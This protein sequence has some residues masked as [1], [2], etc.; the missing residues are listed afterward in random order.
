M[1]ASVSSDG[2]TKIWKISD[3]KI[4]PEKLYNSYDHKN[5]NIIR[6]ISFKNPHY[7]SIEIPTSCCWAPKNPKCIYISYISPNIKLFDIETGKSICDY[8]FNID[9]D[10]PFE[11]QQVNKIAFNINSSMIITANEDRQI[12]LFDSNSSKFIINFLR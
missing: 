7:N 2:L 4:F 1:L 8:S 11:N 10:I 12:R 9:K 3:D 6:Q 5:K